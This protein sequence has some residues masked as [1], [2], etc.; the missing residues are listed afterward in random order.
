MMKVI[1][2]SIPKK[3]QDLIE[4]KLLKDRNFPWYLLDDITYV[5]GGQKRP[6]LSHYFVLHNKVNSAFYGVIEP[7]IKKHVK[8]EVIQIRSFL[9]FPLNKKFA[10]G[11]YDEPHIDYNF[12]HM[13]YLYYVKDSDGDTIFFDKKNNKKII[14]KVTPKKGTLVIFNGLIYHA[15]RQPKNDSRCIININAKKI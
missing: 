15:A 3:Y 7:I 1:K 6:G 14:K 10:T 12:D 4:N 8:S 9:Q 2:N 11:N 5:K 13:V